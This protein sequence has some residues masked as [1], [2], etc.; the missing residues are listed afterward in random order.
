MLMDTNEYITFLESIKAEIT[1]TRAR[2]VGKVNSGSFV[3]TGES[4]RSLTVDRIG[5]PAS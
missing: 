4:A 3:Y 2:A 5:E 1:Q